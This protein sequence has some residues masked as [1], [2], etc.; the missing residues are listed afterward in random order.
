MLPH[1]Q[2]GRRTALKDPETVEIGVCDDG[3]CSMLIVVE[4]CVWMK[5][6][7]GDCGKFLLQSD[8]S[9]GVESDEMSCLGSWPDKA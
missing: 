6:R 9:D 1:S 2:A 7:F 5:D 3:D 8:A 4:S